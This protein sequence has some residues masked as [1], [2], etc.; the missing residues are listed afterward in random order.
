MGKLIRFTWATIIVHAGV[1]TLHGAA[2]QILGVKLTLS[3][4]LF[5]II[6]IAIAPLLAGV[7]LWKKA[8]AAGAIILLLSMAGSLAF[9]VYHHFVAISPDHV[10][11]VSALSHSSWVTV[12]QA[13]AFLLAPVEAVGVVAGIL[14][15]KRGT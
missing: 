5:V 6:V 11:H 15:L 12:F 4:S 1:S 10:A 9:G 3:Q 13:T 2:H 8:S 7:L 14:L